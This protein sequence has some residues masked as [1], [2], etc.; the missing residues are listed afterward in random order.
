[1]IIDSKE[2]SAELLPNYDAVVGSQSLIRNP[3]PTPVV[4][5]FTGW[6]QN[7]MLVM[8]PRDSPVQ[9]PLYRITV[10]LD[11]NPFLPVSY[12]TR[13]FRCGVADTDLVGEFSFALNNKRAVLTMGDTSTRLAN[14]LFSVN[15]N[16]R[17]FN[18]MLG[19]RLHWDCRETT[20]NGS[21]MCIVS[22]DSIQLATFVP[23]P[24]DRSPPLP[25]A[26]LTIFPYGHRLMD[27]IVVSAL[28]VERMLNR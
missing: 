4:Y 15:S 7:S 25:D 28:V 5:N 9:Q 27:D 24:P 16:P 22:T 26:T 13:I 11:M 6:S 8:P 2:K 14:A 17:H 10:E 3:P 20:E 1:M 18:W 21:P 23:P 12:V 19:N